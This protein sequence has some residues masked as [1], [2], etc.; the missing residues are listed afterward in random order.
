MTINDLFF[1]CLNNFN[2]SKTIVESKSVEYTSN[3]RTIQP[4]FSIEENNNNNILN[5]NIIYN[6]NNNKIIENNKIPKIIYKTGKENK[7]KLSPY[8]KKLFIN[9][10]DD[11]K[12]FKLKYYDDNESK[13]F[14]ARYFVKDVLDAY[15]KLKPGAF[16]ADLFRYC[17]LYINGGVYGDLSQIYHKSLTKFIDFDKDELYVVEDTI[18]EPYYEKGIQISFIAARP[19]LEIF[20]NTIIGI[21]ENVKNKYY[22]YNTLDVTGPYHFAKYLKGTNI[23]YKKELYLVNGY[24]ICDKKTNETIITSYHPEHR[25]VIKN[26]PTHYSNMWFNK[27]IYNN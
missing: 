6:N 13:E 5:K 18:H 8:L 1:S 24:K 20:K 16:R 3:Y 21:I 19:K 10:L 26:G 14:I 7:K 11:N 9:F 12:D 15:N 23:K 25:R 27:D 4:I 17:I 22:G 2:R